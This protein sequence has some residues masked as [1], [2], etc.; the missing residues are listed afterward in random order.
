MHGPVEALYFDEALEQ[1]LQEYDYEKHRVTLSEIGE[2]LQSAPRF[3]ENR[4]G[5]RAPL[6]MVGPTKS[7]RLLVVPVEPTHVAGLWYPVTAFEANT[8]DRERYEEGAS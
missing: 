2:V 3:F 8:H 6:I 7:G 4:I 5:R 1:H